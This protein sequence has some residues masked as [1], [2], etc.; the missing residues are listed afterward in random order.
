M[1]VI[2]GSK[3]FIG[4]SFSKYIQQKYS[5]ENVMLINKDNYDLLSEADFSK[6]KIVNVFFCTGNNLQYKKNQKLENYLEEEKTLVIKVFSEIKCSRLRFIY[7]SSAGTVYKDQVEKS[8]DENCTLEPKNNYG[9]YKLQME[10]FLQEEI[11]LGN[12]S[13]FIL[14]ASNIYGELQKSNLGQGLIPT[15]IYN[16]LNNRETVLQF[17]GKEVRD[18]LY[19][20]DFCNALYFIANSSFYEGIN[21]YNLSFGVSRSTLSIMNCIIQ[22]MENRS[23]PINPEHV[24]YG[25]VDKVSQPINS[26]VNSEKFVKD[27][28]WEPKVDID[29]GITKVIEYFIR[30]TNVD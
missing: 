24:K 15:L 17:G 2:I 22:S 11:E 10:K 4:Q 26:L 29:E 30:Y 23:I 3:G 20:E 19:I 25:I 16:L 8:V 27:F 7:F 28:K 9:K 1:I 14:R 13:I 6:H 12:K 21:I 18:Y 5:I